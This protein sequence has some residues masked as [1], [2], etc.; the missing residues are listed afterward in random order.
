MPHH[1]QENLEVAIYDVL[2][3]IYLNIAPKVLN[4]LPEGE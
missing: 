1:C 2:V 4:F 3:P